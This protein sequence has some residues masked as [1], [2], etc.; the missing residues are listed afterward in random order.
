M[1]V[2]WPQL[3][4][5]PAP[6]D[7]VHEMYKQK[8]EGVHP[9]LRMMPTFKVLDSKWRWTQS[10]WDAEGCD[11]F[12][13]KMGTIA[14]VCQLGPVLQKLM[15]Q[16]K[17]VQQCLEHSAFQDKSH[18]HLELRWGAFSLTQVT[19]TK[20]MDSVNPH[21]PPNAPVESLGLLLALPYHSISVSSGWER[22]GPSCPPESFCR[23]IFHSISE[24]VWKL[25]FLA[26]PESSHN[27]AFASRATQLQLFL[28]F[29]WRMEYLLLPTWLG[30]RNK[31]NP[32]FPYWP[33]CSKPSD[34]CLTCSF[35]NVIMEK[36]N[37]HYN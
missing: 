23:L 32:H 26:S 6:S 1:S 14:H 15:W 9:Q 37:S 25:L 7:P 27:R 17:D 13:L 29:T 18:P 21:G 33:V 16:L 19:S 11:S 35:W 2:N 5:S 20:E 12:L 8:G 30:Q 24:S 31:I 10:P 28:L 34:M 4:T 3:Q 22:P 36:R